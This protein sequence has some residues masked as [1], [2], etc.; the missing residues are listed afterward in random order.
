[1]GP[2]DLSQ[3]L[4]RPGE[5][6]QRGVG[7]TAALAV[8]RGLVHLR[9]AAAGFTAT[10]AYLART[11]IVDEFFHRLLDLLVMQAT[12]AVA[13][14]AFAVAELCGIFLLEAHPA[15]RQAGGRARHS[16]PPLDF[17]PPP[18]PRASREPPWSAGTEATERAVSARRR[19]GTRGGG[20]P[21]A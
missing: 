11:N 20:P 18:G 9:D 13:P 4:G 2:S 17:R 5:G 8:G 15:D 1:M 19:S 7:L 14:A 10:P 12:G 16:A 6:R 3:A 21:G